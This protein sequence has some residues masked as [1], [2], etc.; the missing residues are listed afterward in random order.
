MM[1]RFS[2][3]FGYLDNE[4]DILD[5]IWSPSIG[6]RNLLSLYLKV[7]RSHHVRRKSQEIPTLIG[8]K[9]RRIHT[10][11]F[12]EDLMVKN[13]PRNSSPI[14]LINSK[15]GIKNQEKRKF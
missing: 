5:M 13:N 15:F 14:R 3:C 7:K 11:G 4:L 6:P 10:V 9:E 12:Y 1:A 2:L 8:K